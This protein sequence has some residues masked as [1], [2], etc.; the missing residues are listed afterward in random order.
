MSN[1]Y[2]LDACALL[3]FINNEP[4]ADR[5]EAILR[6]ALNGNAEVFMNK[7]NVFEVYY[8]IYRSQGKEKADE[9]YRL[10]Q[11][12][13]INIIDA[14]DDAVFTEAARLKTKFRM[15]LAD[16]IA[17]GEAVYQ[18]AVVVSSDHHEFDIVSSQENIVFDWIR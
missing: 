17:L 2:V 15:S 13:P 7:I 6:D 11:I 10:I 4:G 16:S 1:A 8:G 14:L 18:N 3:A 12:Q 9:I 5:V